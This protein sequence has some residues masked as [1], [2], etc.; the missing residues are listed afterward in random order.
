MAQ[1]DSGATSDG[2]G[3]SKLAAFLLS[4]GPGIIV[5]LA[6][7][8]T[9]DL[10]DASVSGANYGY[11]L[12]WVLVIA[13]ACRFFVASSLA[14]YVL[15]NGQEDETILDGYAR[16]WRGYPLLLGISAAILGFVYHSYLILAG[17][18]AL[19]NL[20]GR[21]GGEE[22][23][24]FLWALVVV[25]L[26]IFMVT[27]KNRY[28]SLEIVAQLTLLALLVSF[29]IAIIG[30]GINVEAFFRGL[31]F[32]L[33]ADV[34]PVSSLAI[35]IA[36]IGSVGGSAANLLYPYLVRDRGWNGPSYRRKQVGE[37]AFAVGTLLVLVLS[38]WIVAAETMR[39][40][41]G[42]LEGTDDLA[43][44]MGLAIGPIGPTLFWIALF[45]V[46]FDNIPAQAYVFSRMCVESVHKS[47][48]QRR[49]RY[50]NSLP[51]SSTET[52][53]S[54]GSA[55]DDA[56]EEDTAKDSVIRDPLML[57]LQIGVLI[58]PPVIFSLPF[59]PDLIIVTV[60]GNA[61]SVVTIPAII[62]GL[63]LLTSSR[64]FMLPGYANS[65]WEMSI[66]IV[67]GMIGLWATYKLIG[68]L[69]NI[70][71]NLY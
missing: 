59:A 55:G 44:M 48:P 61:L 66:L 18:T 36:F 8:G 30:S 60:L 42:A 67:I 14:K 52:G 3:R 13:L 9:G 11:D 43:N 47:F 26:S 71:G 2:R 51:Q 16:L 41:E 15:C 19:Y 68:E 27:R 17:G 34:G 38:I 33:P 69:V 37:L 46:V 21:V 35:T 57:W 22:W 20:F 29:L 31:A 32:E 40:Q 63:I 4:L 70:I 65:W 28:R 50:E 5:A 64:R 58:I 49:R 23:G 24:V 56:A 1:S 39:G 10:I 25:A 62:I 54:D 45:F 7:L 53:Q 12:I 6:W